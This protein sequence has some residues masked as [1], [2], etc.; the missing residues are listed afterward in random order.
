MKRV[1][2]L[3]PMALFACGDDGGSGTPIDAA[4]SGSDAGS[5]AKVM[6]VTCPATPDATV[7]TVNTTDA[8]MPMNT[9]ISVGGT[10]KFV[11]STM[12]NVE[13]NPI[14]AMSDPGTRVD[15]GETKCLKFSAAGT[16]GIYC[17]THSFAGT[18]TV[19]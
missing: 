12:H 1:A 5:A 9:T 18:I 11:M 15:Y 4:G 14:A 8:F 2:L 7:T 6:T 19:Q 13:P 17:A 16:Y 10:V 3:F